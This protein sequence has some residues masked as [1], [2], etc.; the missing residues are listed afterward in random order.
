MNYHKSHIKVLEFLARDLPKKSLTKISDI[1]TAQFKKEQY[2]ERVARN[3]IRK[4]INE[5]LVEIAHRG[6]YRLTAAGAKFAS[7]QL[8]TGA[9]VAADAKAAKKAVPVAAKRR[10]RPPKAKLDVTPMVV[11]KRRGRPPKVVVEAVQ[12]KRRGRPPK[13][14]A[15]QTL[16]KDVPVVAKR[17]G[18]PPK[19]AAPVVVE[20]PVAKKRGRPKKVVDAA[21]VTP[22]AEGVKRRG[23]PPGSKNKPKVV[24]YN[25]IEPAKI[26][27][28]AVKEY[29]EPVINEDEENLDKA[30]INEE[31]LAALGL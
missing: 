29:V 24:E 1:A 22:P 11:K 2:P 30:G 16:L 31:E 12:P 9:Y 10:G 8:I 7:K 4:P 25:H 5:G 27:K 20:A 19:N 3:S 21:P 14:P 18:R 6:E 23:R 13:N 15:Q 17:R 26:E 28:P